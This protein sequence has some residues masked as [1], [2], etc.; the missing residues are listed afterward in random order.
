MIEVHV[1]NDPTE[2]ERIKNRHQIPADSVILAASEDDRAVGFVALTHK[3]ADMTLCAV[4][5]ADDAVCELLLRAAF[6]YGERRGV[7]QVTAEFSEPQTVLSSLGFR[8][9]DRQFT[10]GVNNVVHM[11]R[12]CEAHGN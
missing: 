11:C 4:E 5:Y 10:A 6:S 7:R 2:L 9:I 3:G 12:N 1:Q 8:L